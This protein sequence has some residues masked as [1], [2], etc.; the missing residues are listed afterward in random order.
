MAGRAVARPMERSGC[1]WRRPARRRRRRD[2]SNNKSNID[3][4]NNDDDDDD[5]NNNLR[6]RSA[7]GERGRNS[8]EV[9]RPA[10]RE[11]DLGAGSRP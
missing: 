4:D 5:N 1:F 7:P 3:T 2:N 10:L 6:S 8:A 9:M 11:R